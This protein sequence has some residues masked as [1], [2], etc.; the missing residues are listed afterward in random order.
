MAAA[1]GLPLSEAKRQKT[2]TAARE[3]SQKRLP[4]FT[5]NSDHDVACCLLLARLVHIVHGAVLLRLAR[6]VQRRR[7]RV[8]VRVQLLEAHAR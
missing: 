8:R 6:L 4:C 7:L 5:P 2:E 1:A 3:H